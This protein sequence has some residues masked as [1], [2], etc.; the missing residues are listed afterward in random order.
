MGKQPRRCG[1][2][3]TLSNLQRSTTRSAQGWTTCRYELQVYGCSP[4]VILDNEGGQPPGFSLGGFAR[5][6]LLHSPSAFASASGCP[7]ILQHM[8][9]TGGE[10]ATNRYV[11]DDA[12]P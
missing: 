2:Q 9:D 4:P 8:G 7:T 10:V 3:F 12:A 6:I 5:M 1:I 11:F